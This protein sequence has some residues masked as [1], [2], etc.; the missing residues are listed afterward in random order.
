MNDNFKTSKFTNHFE[1]IM[2]KISKK[3]CAHSVFHRC[4]ETC[5]WFPK[6]M[7]F[8]YSCKWKS[9]RQKVSMNRWEKIK[10]LEA[11]LHICTGFILCT[12]FVSFHLNLSLPGLSTTKWERQS[13]ALEV[14]GNIVNCVTQR[15]EHSRPSSWSSCFYSHKSWITQHSFVL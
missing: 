9:W 12:C 7:N 11:S 6:V 1:N 10:G 4:P 5:S 3:K 15:L 2:N 8:W 13:S 14:V